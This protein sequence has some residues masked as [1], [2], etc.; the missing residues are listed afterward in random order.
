MAEHAETEPIVI[1][2]V[3]AV[4]ETAWRRLWSGYIDF[5]GAELSEAVT[6]ATWQRLLAPG[7]GM[8]GRIAEWKGAV[9]GFSVYV[10]HPG[11][12]LSGRANG[13]SQLYWHTRKGNA[14]ARR[15]YGKFATADD[16]VRYRLF[17]D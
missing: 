5:Y 2:D 4:D 1:R 11:P 13:W 16:F 7:T 17:L 3:L 8:F 10:L 15:L 9:A 6:S 14:E 12:R